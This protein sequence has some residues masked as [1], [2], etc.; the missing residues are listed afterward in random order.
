VEP[1]CGRPEV[2]TVIPTN[3]FNVVAIGQLGNSERLSVAAGDTT[4][5]IIGEI[6]MWNR[7]LD[8]DDR[9]AAEAYLSWKWLGTTAPGYSALNNATVTGSGSITA[10]D[11]SLL[12]KFDAGC[13]ATV[14]V[15]SSAL[16]FH[17]AGG[18]ITDALSFG[19]CELSLPAACTISLTAEGQIAAGDY[20]LITCGSGLDGTV[21][22]LAQDKVG[23]MALSLI[24]T[25]SALVLRAMPAGTVIMFR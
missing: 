16:A 12:P 23:S 5:E 22:T 25:D 1:F 11:I 4:A 8:D 15:P 21:F 2:F 9:E 6:L 10:A 17:Y 20:P 18:A 13:T 7:A 19:A 14:A 3:T 24:K